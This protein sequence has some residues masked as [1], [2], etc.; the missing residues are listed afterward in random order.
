MRIDSRVVVDGAWAYI[1]AQ[2]LI[3]LG[4]NL[5]DRTAQLDLAA[6]LLCGHPQI[7]CDGAQ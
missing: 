2:C 7:H 4:S 1:M 6:E 5:G 3:G